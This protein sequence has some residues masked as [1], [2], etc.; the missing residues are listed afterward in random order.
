[1]S[2]P[3]DPGTYVRLKDVGVCVAMDY[4]PVEDYVYWTDVSKE[5]ISRA[6]STGEGKCY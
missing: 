1:M 3:D 2:D 6:R 5:T 4:D